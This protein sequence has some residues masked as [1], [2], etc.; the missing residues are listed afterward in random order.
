MNL[1]VLSG[2]IVKDPEL[3]YTPKGNP[4][5]KTSICW[6]E[7]QKTLVGDKEKWEEFPNFFNI[8]I[9]GKMAEIF[10]EKVKKGFLVLIEGKIKMRSWKK[11]GVT[12]YA[13]EIHF[14]RW[15]ILRKKNDDVVTPEDNS[16]INIPPEVE[17]M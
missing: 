7:K 16:D 14:R 10:V 8:I 4:I 17:E 6:N 9:V 1:L 2:N 11:E 12:K 15:E 3:A 13:F 5:A